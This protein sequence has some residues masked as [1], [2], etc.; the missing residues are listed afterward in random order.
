MN[1]R[2]SLTATSR[3]WV[4]LAT[5]S[6][7]LA[8]HGADVGQVGV[9]RRQ[10]IAAGGQRGYQQL[11]VADGAED[12][13]AVIAQCRDRLRQFDHRVPGGI[14]LAAQILRR[15]VDEL[16]DRALGLPGWWAAGSR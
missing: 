14:A 9:E 15:A 7:L 1:P 8:R 3:A 6:G 10:Q 2:R 11:Q 12:V 4:A 5:S 13:G 16:A